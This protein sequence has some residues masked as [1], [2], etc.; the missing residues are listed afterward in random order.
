MPVASQENAWAIERMTLAVFAAAFLALLVLKLGTLDDPPAWD[1]AFSVFPAA[2]TLAATGFDFGGLLNAP[3]YADGGPNV[4]PL[5][6]V[7]IGTAVVLAL[8]DNP[9]TALRVLHVIHLLVAASA[10]AGLFRLAARVL[11]RWLAVA[12]AVAGMAA[13]V[14]ITQAG[15][16]YLEMPLLAATAW[17]LVAWLER[18][19]GAALLFVGIATVIKQPGLATGG[20]LALATLIDPDRRNRS[21]D[22][23]MVLV[24]LPVALITFDLLV[25]GD[26]GPVRSV[27][28]DQLD[29]AITQSSLFASR[30][31]DL[32]IV[33]ALYL[34]VRPLASER[35]LLGSSSLDL[36]VDRLETAIG[37]LAVAFL[38]FYAVT[39]FIGVV[40][41]PRYWIQLLPFL[42]LALVLG[43]RR[44]ASLP[45]SLG[46]TAGVAVLFLVNIS[47]LLYPSAGQSN[48]ALL[49]R[50]GEYAPLLELSRRTAAAIAELPD[51]VPV[52]YSHA[53]HYRVR[54]PASGYVTAPVTHGTSVLTIPESRRSTLATYPDDFFVVVT[55]LRLG[56]ETLEWLLA[57]AA[58]SAEYDVEV[59]TY[60]EGEFSASIARV[61]KAG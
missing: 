44:V 20:A 32:L 4:H 6:L 59:T 37:S 42:L 16:V 15:M 40:V 27:S 34:V 12:V 1:A 18:R 19:P 21:F 36:E 45:V 25:R 41:L 49:E 28:L 54:Y 58:A 22:R 8:I 9:D 30:L 46:V 5:S 14:V 23:A 17:A 43:L 53:D 26:A 2:E 48:F 52:F 47:G 60:D 57:S 51:D 13:S 31:P 38:G 33:L 35:P 55:E 24:L 61:T 7:T 56:G 50:S 3:G 10:V 11:D 39:G 29:V